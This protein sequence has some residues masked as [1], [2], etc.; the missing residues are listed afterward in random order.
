MKDFEDKKV[1]SSRGLGSPKIIETKGSIS[2]KCKW[3]A[4]WGRYLPKTI[5]VVEKNQKGVH[6]QW[7]LRKNIRLQ[8]LDFIKKSVIGAERKIFEI[9]EEK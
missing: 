1:S 4:D 5:F 3:R 6:L 9:V 7:F 8:K 2:F